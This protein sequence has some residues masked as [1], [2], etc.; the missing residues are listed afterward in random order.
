MTCDTRQGC[1]P[2]HVEEAVCARYVWLAASCPS[3]AWRRTGRMEWKDALCVAVRCVVVAAVCHKTRM[4]GT[5]CGRQ[6]VTEAVAVG[7]AVGAAQ[8]CRVEPHI[9]SHAC[10]PTCCRGR[11][12]RP[13]PTTPHCHCQ[14]PTTCCRVRRETGRTREATADWERWTG[15]EPTHCH[16][17]CQHSDCDLR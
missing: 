8:S 7:V 1:C 10:G 2:W 9:P 11:H 5:M 14:Q 13:R 16:R 15:R 12:V 6:R 3:S 4:A 17:D